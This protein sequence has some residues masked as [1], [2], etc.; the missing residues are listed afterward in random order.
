MNELRVVCS[1]VTPAYVQEG[2]V[3]DDEVT[4]C[5]FTH[6]TILASPEGLARYPWGSRD[7]QNVCLPCFVQVMSDLVADKLGADA[8]T[9]LA[10][11]LSH[12]RR[13][14]TTVQVSGARRSLSPCL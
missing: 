3:C 14:E 2:G 7:Q 10:A 6:P 9:V 5:A 12:G 8:G 13:F 4:S 1:N 11:M